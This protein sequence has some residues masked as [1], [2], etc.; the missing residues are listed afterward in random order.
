MLAKAGPTLF[1]SYGESQGFRVFGYELYSGWLPSCSWACHSQ[2]CLVLKDFSNVAPMF[3]L[4]L[5]KISLL[6]TGWLLEGTVSLFT[7]G[8]LADSFYKSFIS[9][10]QEWTRPGRSL[11]HSGP[12]HWFTASLLLPFPGC[13]CWTWNRISPSKD[14]APRL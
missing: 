2:R 5:E 14:S 7:L 1:E 10:V 6:D 4:D 12:T 8:W 3:S 9:W 11:P 13:R